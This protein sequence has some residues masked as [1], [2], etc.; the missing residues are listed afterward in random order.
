MK[1]RILTA[2]IGIPLLTFATL[3]Q[4]IYPML[5]IALLVAIIGIIE[6]FRAELTSFFQL[7]WL[8]LPIIIFGSIYLNFEIS[9]RISLL[10]LTLSAVLLF[11]GKSS[12][13]P[14]VVRAN[15]LCIGWV[16]IS[17]MTFVAIQ[18]RS[19]KI[20]GELFQ[21]NN[22]SLSLLIL[23]SLWAGDTFAY[24]VGSAIGK[25]KIAPAVSPKKSWEG[26]IANLIASA[27]VG[28][29]VSSPFSIPPPIGL[30]IGISCGLF[31]QLGDF[32]Q[33]A[34]K[35]SHGIKDSGSLLPGHGGV[36]DRF[37]SLLFAAPV[38]AILVNAIPA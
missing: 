12:P 9:T 20:D 2:F 13:F 34:W 35:R 18:F 33:S 28:W 19:S 23:L 6:I 10:A 1:Q 11:G 32:A 26:A 22:G 17:L 15:T 27:A 8:A 36:L 21:F 14:Q 4:S 3:S 24:F 25:H 37:D 5:L 30:A 29:F 16:G 38:A 31:G 7:G